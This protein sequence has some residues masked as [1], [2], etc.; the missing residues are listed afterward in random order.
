MPNCA[1]PLA[2]AAFST[3]TWYTMTTPRRKEPYDILMDYCH[4]KRVRFGKPPMARLFI[5]F[6][7]K[8]FR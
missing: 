7:R 6:C 5:T 2:F 4:H 8:F 1:Q 3:A